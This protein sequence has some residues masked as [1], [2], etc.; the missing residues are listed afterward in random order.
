M[1]IDPTRFAQAE[2][3]DGMSTA[4]S[5]ILGI[6]LSLGCAS[7]VGIVGLTLLMPL[8]TVLGAASMGVV[9]AAFGIL[10][11]GYLL[12]FVLVVTGLPEGLTLHRRVSLERW[13]RAGSGSE[14]AASAM[15][16]LTACAAAHLA[17]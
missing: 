9:F 3:G 15:L 1:P 12:P 4:G 10:A 6:G 5:F 2:Q 11:F 8:L 17:A 7:C 14:S 16:C 13:L